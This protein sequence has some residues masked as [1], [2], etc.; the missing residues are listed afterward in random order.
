VPAV[1]FKLEPLLRRH[2]KSVLALAKASGLAKTTVY[3]IVNNKAKA[4]ELET[5]GKLVDGLERL[6]GETI[7]FNDVL[8]KEPPK[9]NPL[10]EELLKDVKPFDWEEMKKLIPDW[11]PEERAENERVWA[12]IEREK[13]EARQRPSERERQ[14]LEIFGVTE[15]EPQGSK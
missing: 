9:Q 13:E 14:L 7:T 11:T 1:H 2:N 6:T 8:E 3:N 5:L 12:E 15:P 4:V 10:L